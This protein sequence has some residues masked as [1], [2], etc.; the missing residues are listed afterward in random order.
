MIDAAATLVATLAQTTVPVP[1]GRLAGW[2]AIM[3][4]IVIA[5]Q[6]IGFEFGPILIIL[7]VVG[8]VAF[9]VG[10]P[11]LSNIGTGLPAPSRRRSTSGA[12]DRI[13]A[14]SPVVGRG[15]GAPGAPPRPAV[16]A[17]A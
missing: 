4:G 1:A 16:T 13:P 3:L 7:L 10:R 2:L 14:T 17:V 15:A 5:V 12:R 8:I 9:L 6:A 11:I